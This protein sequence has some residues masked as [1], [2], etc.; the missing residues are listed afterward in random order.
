MDYHETDYLSLVKKGQAW[1]LFIPSF[2]P[3]I[4]VI[5]TRTYYTDSSFF[6]SQTLS[7][8][9][10]DQRKKNMLHEHVSLAALLKSYNKRTT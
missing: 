2:K 1:R 5:I 3:S 7:V 4:I 10:I 8:Y 9:S 6:L